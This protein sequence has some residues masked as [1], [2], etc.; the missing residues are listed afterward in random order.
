MAAPR[1]LVDP[2]ANGISQATVA[3]GGSN[4][5]VGDVLTVVQSGA[6][7]GQV[8]VTQVNNG[9]VVSLQIMA[10]GVGYSTANGLSATGGHGSGAAVNVTN[11]FWLQEIIYS[12]NNDFRS[13]GVGYTANSNAWV[14]VTNNDYGYENDASALA[15]EYAVAAHAP[16]GGYWASSEQAAFLSRTYNDIDDPTQTS[17]TTT[18]QDAANQSN[19]NWVLS[20]GLLG[21]GG[22]GHNDAT[23]AQLPAADPHYSTANYY[24]NTV[25]MLPGSG[26]SGVD[27]TDSTYGLITAQSNTGVLTVSGWYTGTGGTGSAPALNQIVSATYASGLTGVVGTAG[28]L[29]CLD[30]GGN[31]YGLLPLTGT[32]TIAGGST[33]RI[34]GPYAFASAPA[35]AAVNT[36]CSTASA[37]GTATVSTTLGTQYTIFDTFTLSTTTAGAAA[38]ATFTKTTNLSSLVNVGDAV[39]AT[40]GWWSDFYVGSN[41]SIVTAVGTNT[42]SVINS[43]S[44][45]A[46]TSTPQLAWRFPPWTAGDCGR[47]WVAKQQFYRAQGVESVLYGAAANNG[48]SIYN[49][50]GMLSLPDTASNGGGADP[51]SLQTLD[52]VIAAYGDDSRA[53]RD[54][55]RINSVMF[56]YGVVRP[57]LDFNSV[58]RL[59]NGPAYSNDLDRGGMSEYLWTMAD[60]VPGYPSL[61][62]QWTSSLSTWYQF[63]TLPQLLSGYGFKAGWAGQVGYGGG[64]GQLYSTAIVIGGLASDPSFFFAPSSNQAGWFRNFAENFNTAGGSYAGGGGNMWGSNLS[65]GMALTF[66]YQDPRVADIPYTNQPLQWGPNPSYTPPT[67]AATGWPHLFQ[68]DAAISRTCWECSSGTLVLFDN[69]TFTDDCG[70]YDSPRFGN[71][72]AWKGGAVLLGGDQNPSNNF[73]CADPSVTGDTFQFKGPTGSGNFLIG[74]Q[75]TIGITPI[76]AWA[77]ANAGTYGTQFGD[78][79]SRY[80]AACGNEA[81]GYDT[82][83]LNITLDHA[84]R[85]FVHLKKNGNDEW[86]FQFDDVALAGNSPTASL[87][88][89]WHLHY[90]QNGQTQSGFG[91]YTTGSTTYLGANVI[92]ELE[93]GNSGRTYGLMTYVASP[94][95]IALNDDCVG[96]GGGQCSPGSTYSGG[97]GYTHRFT[98]ASGSSVGAN[99]S[100]F[101]SV[102]GHKLMDSLTDTTFTTANLNPDA[103]WTGVQLTGAKSTGI[104]LFAVGGSTRSAMTSFTTN[105]SGTGD[106]MIM[107]LKPGTYSLTVGGVPVSGSP[108]TVGSGDGTIYFSSPAGTVVLTSGSPSSPTSLQGQMSVT[109]NVTIH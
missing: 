51:V 3:S 41:E 20:A 80:A 5:G 28:Q 95:T 70:V 88:M 26:G 106:W 69:A 6:S 48:F 91:G 90:T 27:Y 97:N 87:P 7:G 25:M 72:S 57:L 107:G 13:G 108:F 93:D 29:I 43:S 53:T 4:Y 66:L 12:L 45:P 76:T 86:L 81:P 42:L 56:D 10:A 38:T 11:N 21:P 89:A 54:L 55:A 52:L 24:V 98:V 96:L 103:N 14:N 73:W 49:N 84:V 64:N 62:G 109:G 22:S 2:T 63:E 23:H 75:P 83:G 101:V 65:Y 37:S 61:Y 104:A 40:N 79:Q 99:V 44:V 9:V 60:T 82:A 46:S 16:E 50:K 94:L 30:F 105:F 18:N 74:V 36:S 33:I 59:R 78:S 1:F 68:G 47:L 102:V 67:T 15:L 8:M 19:H 100:K 32:N 34:T 35:T 71:L 77:S 92:K 17:C 31:S 85:C 58:G 39:M